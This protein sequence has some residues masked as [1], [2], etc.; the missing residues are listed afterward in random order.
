MKKKRKKS[1][2]TYIDK[3]LN[4]FKSGPI[5]PIFPKHIY[6]YNNILRSC[7][8][9]V[10]LLISLKTVK[11]ISLGPGMNSSQSVSKKTDAAE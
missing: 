2:R 11:P 10:R 7:A 3:E 9:A 5:Y 6:V 8:T 4:N 1:F